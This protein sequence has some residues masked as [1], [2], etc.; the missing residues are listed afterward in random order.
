MKM[1]FLLPIMAII[2]M[3]FVACGSD[4]DDPAPPHEVGNWNLSQ[5]ALKNVPTAYSYNEGAVFELNEV[6]LGIS[7]YELQLN[8]N[9]SFS[10]SVSFTGSLPEDDDG[11]YVI[12]DS[13]ITLQSNDSSD[14][15]V[16]DV[17]K[18][19]NDDLWL[20]LPLQFGLIK[21]TI[22]DTL[23][24]EY[25]NTLSDT[26]KDALFDPVNLDFVLVFERGQ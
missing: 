14:P 11:T 21:N 12:T 17:Q 15:E 4:S 6:N 9:L 24:N 16:F 22:L 20:S 1:K 26:E 2:S 3:V 19:L 5:Y 10:R 7:A 25:Y 8:Q 13:E 23:T 18:N